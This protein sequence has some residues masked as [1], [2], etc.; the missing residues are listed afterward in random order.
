IPVE[1][2]QK[3]TTQKYISFL[4]DQK[5]RITKRRLPW[6]DWVKLSKE[7][8][9]QK[10]REA[11]EEIQA[12]AAFY[13]RH[14]QLHEDIQNYCRTLFKVAAEALRKYQETKERLGMIDFIDQEQRLLDALKQPEVFEP[15]KEELELLLVDE[16]QDTSPIQLALFL[17][18][19]E[20]AREAVFVGDIKQAIY[21]FRGSDPDLMLAVQREIE[22]QGHQVQIL[23]TSYR[24]RPALVDYTNALF[25]PAFSD[26]IPEDQVRLTP[27]R[28]EV[29]GEPAVAHWILCGKNT[30]SH[31]DALAFGIERLVDSGYRVEDKESGSLRKVRY[32]DIAVLA[33]TNYKVSA[34]AQTLAKR[35]IPIQMERPGL[36]KTPEARLV[37]SCIRRLADPKDTLA[38]A[39]ILSLSEC[40][41]AE[42]WLEARLKDLE[43]GTPDHAWK[44]AEGGDYPVL[45]AVSRTRDRIR[46]LSPSEALSAVMDVAQLR[47]I[48]STWG[49]NAW[50]VR[51]RLQNLNALVGFAKKFEDHC[52]THQKAA[53]IA[54]LLDWFEKLNTAKLDTQPGDPRS[55]AVQILTHHRAKGLEWPVVIAMDLNSDLKSRT[56]GLN[57]ISEN[58]RLDLQDPLSD[59][60]LRFWPYPFGGQRS[61]IPVLETLNQSEFGKTCEQR[62]Q[63]ESIRLL[64]VS[65]TR[66]RDLLVI[67][68][69]EK[70]STGEWMKLLQADWMLPAGDTLALPDGNRI[71]AACWKLDASEK[72]DTGEPAPFQPFW[73]SGNQA[74]LEKLPAILSPSDFAPCSDARIAGRMISGTPLPITNAG[75]TESLG[76]FLHHVLAA[77]AVNPL[78]KD[79]LEKVQNAVAGWG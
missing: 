76:T 10:S 75:T 66:A 25:I 1:K 4:H 22:N 40:L 18:L 8:P 9:A 55:D 14:P 69:P 37:L 13:D 23:E 62:D 21:G 39:E 15:L 24:S 42:T 74:F 20:A 57:V 52:V 48:V 70:K 6:S 7:T 12:A 31:H 17:K 27:S 43:S 44:T 64:Y 32:G 78:R 77:E 35:G 50:R 61:G 29:T 49:P 38:G 33:R 72:P 54:G 60:S 56:W 36:L 73:F 5:T 79:A 28:K 34:I 16:F 30:A 2:D 53:T 11:A 68:L 41:A 3:I 58:P 65:L 46:E 71:P 45:K 59:R 19:A 26:H 67:P 47:H 63:A 51:Q